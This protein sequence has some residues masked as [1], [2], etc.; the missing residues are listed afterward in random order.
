M[1]LSLVAPAFLLLVFTL[2]F[3]LVRRSSPGERM[4]A[5]PG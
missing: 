1:L 2:I 5:N 4:H 3:G